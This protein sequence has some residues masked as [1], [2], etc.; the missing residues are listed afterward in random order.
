MMKKEPEEENLTSTDVALQSDSDGDPEE[1]VI[2]IHKSGLMS[3]NGQ[4]AP[5]NMMEL[6]SHNQCL[7]LSQN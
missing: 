4:L 6:A 7:A 3:E 5:V 2:E 1:R